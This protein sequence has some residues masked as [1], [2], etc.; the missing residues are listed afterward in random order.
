MDNVVIRG[1]GH[2]HNEERTL[3]DFRVA[4]TLK[5]FIKRV[6]PSYPE[7]TFDVIGS[8]RVDVSDFAEELGT[9]KV[10]IR[11][12]G[13]S[14][15]DVL[16]LHSPKMVDKRNQK[17][18]TASMDS[19][20]KVFARYFKSTPMEKVLW[21]RL[22]KI[23]WRETRLAQNADAEIINLL[24]SRVLDVVKAG[25]ERVGT[26][27]ELLEVSQDQQEQ[28]LNLIA[29]A[30]YVDTDSF[31]EEHT[32]IA[33]TPKGYARLV[34]DAV[35]FSDAVPE[36]LKQPVALLKIAKSE[37]YIE[38]VGVLRNLPFPTYVCKNPPSV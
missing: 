2:V 33:K 8:G 32:L 11:G 22:Q 18:R 29:R 28:L 36:E 34:D 13:L 25:S 27:R 35:A 15:E 3:D 16:E 26:L 5:E 24:R 23:A 17:T 20:V 6:A 9:I 10:D 14:F 37:E 19:A 21:D 30:A 7:F 38:G 12:R 1:Y 31:M 4:P